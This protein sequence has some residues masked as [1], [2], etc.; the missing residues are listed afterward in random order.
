MGLKQV[1]T[2]EHAQEHAKRIAAAFTKYGAQLSVPYPV[3]ALVE[4][5]AVLH[6]HMPKEDAPTKDEL[7]L[8]KRQLTAALAREA[9]C[10]GKK[11]PE[12][13]GRFEQ[14]REEERLAGA[15]FKTPLELAYGD[16]DDPTLP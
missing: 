10:K 13:D 7:T 15:K 6:G 4:I 14:E 12:Y 2:K 11:E 1:M 8:V 16:S 3:S 9:K 5:I